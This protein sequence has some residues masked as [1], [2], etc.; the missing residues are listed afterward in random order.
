MVRLVTLNTA[1][2]KKLIYRIDEF[3]FRQYVLIDI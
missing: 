3:I 2:I 1:K